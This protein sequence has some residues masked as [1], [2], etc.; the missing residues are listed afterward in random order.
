MAVSSVVHLLN[1]FFKKKKKKKLK[2][3]EVKGGRITKF[4]IENHLSKIN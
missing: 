3:K 1:S 2:R 4:K